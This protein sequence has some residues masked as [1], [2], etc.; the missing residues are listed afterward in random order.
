VNFQR[1]VL[2]AADRAGMILGGH[3]RKLMGQYE[4]REGFQS[5]D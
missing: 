1:P 2:S 4:V 3:K 5:I